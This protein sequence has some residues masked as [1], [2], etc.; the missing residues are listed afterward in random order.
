MSCSCKCRTGCRSRTC[1]CRKNEARCG[2]NCK[3]TDCQNRQDTQPDLMS[4]SMEVNTAEFLRLRQN[5]EE[6]FMRILR[7][8]V[9][10]L[11]ASQTIKVVTALEI[12][13]LPNSVKKMKLQE[14]K[15]RLNC[16]AKLVSL[17]GISENIGSILGGNSTQRRKTLAPPHKD[18]IE[19]KNTRVKIKE[20]D[21]V[22]RLIK[23]G[24][25]NA[26]APAPSAPSIRTAAKAQN[27]MNSHPRSPGLTV[28]KPGPLSPGLRNAHY[29]QSQQN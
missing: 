25:A 1:T 14:F 28:S 10:S 12:A 22:D 26:N 11:K 19:Q 24:G 20:K 6:A 2:Q 5:K 21:Q 13:K 23:P 4:Q 27:V 29:S 3:C 15:N 8:R 7:L 17:E 16:N 18:K 9:A